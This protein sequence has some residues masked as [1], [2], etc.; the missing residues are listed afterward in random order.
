MLSWA[1]AP[2]AGGAYALGL[3]GALALV[4]CLLAR[5]LWSR[6]LERASHA[7]LP[8]LRLPTKLEPVEGLDPGPDSGLYLTLRELLKYS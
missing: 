2:W 8:P 6:V 5:C 7:G 1:F 4:P 3:L